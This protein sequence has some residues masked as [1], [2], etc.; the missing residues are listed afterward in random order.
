M[1]KCYIVGAGEFHGNFTPDSSDLVIAADGGYNSLIQHGIRCDLL[2][3]DFD[4]IE[5]MPKDIQCIRF[6][7]EKDDTDSFLAYR[8][9]AKRGYTDFI[10]FGGT[11]GRLDHT[12]SNLSLLNY[13]RQNGHRATIEGEREQILLIKDESVSFSVPKGRHVSIFAVGGRARG[14]TIDGLKYSLKNGEL[15]VEFPL[16]T[17]N[18]SLGEEAVVSVSDGTLLIMLEK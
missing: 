2:I 11:G 5:R 3:G 18:L 9:G 17:S 10:L 14:V 8:E 12:Y 7:V 6:P 15:S 13:A 4:S 16:A 1:N